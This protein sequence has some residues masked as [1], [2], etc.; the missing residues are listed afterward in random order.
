[1]EET[2]I[3]DN[4]ILL[5]WTE[6]Q[7][8]RLAHWWK[9]P[10]ALTVAFSKPQLETVHNAHLQWRQQLRTGGVESRAIMIVLQI[11]LKTASQLACYGQLTGAIVTQPIGS[12]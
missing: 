5:Y 7:Y 10:A 11:T 3:V 4:R 6:I 1:M 2:N 8:Q 12:L 9:F